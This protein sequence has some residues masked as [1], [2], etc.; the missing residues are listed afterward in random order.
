VI[1]REISDP[2]ALTLLK[3]EYRDGDIVVV[4]ASADG[5]LTFS[6]QQPV[7]ID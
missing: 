6:S 1:Q 5:A 2:I 3:G 7:S 4:D